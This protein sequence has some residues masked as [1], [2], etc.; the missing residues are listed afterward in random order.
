MWPFYNCVK[1]DK[2]ELCDTRTLSR[3]SILLTNKA[4]GNLFSTSISHSRPQI[5][6]TQSRAIGDLIWR[7]KDVNDIVEDWLLT[8]SK[9]LPP[10]LQQIEFLSCCQHRLLTLFPIALNEAILIVVQY[11]MT[12]KQIYCIAE[13]LYLGALNP[14]VSLC[15]P[16]TLRNENKQC[17]SRKGK[18]TFQ[19][20]SLL[21]A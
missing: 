14:F 19:I 9:L 15:S 5:I 10:F 6:W 8:D 18:Y 16:F 17:W 13:F 20:S 11:L 21:V 4:L 3:A 2:T 1:V 12:T 7:K